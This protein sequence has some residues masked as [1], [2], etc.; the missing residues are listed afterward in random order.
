[1]KSTKIKKNEVIFTNKTEKG[2]MNCFWIDG[3]LKEDGTHYFSLGING[4]NSSVI[5]RYDQQFT[6]EDAK[7]IVKFLKNKIKENGQR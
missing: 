5:G 1:M 6:L 2:G 7:V 4:K 3:F